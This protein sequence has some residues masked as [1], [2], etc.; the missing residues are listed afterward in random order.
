VDQK[1]EQA[2]VWVK[3]GRGQPSISV[4]LQ[5][6]IYKKLVRDNQLKPGRNHD[7][8]W[9]FIHKQTLLWVKEGGVPGVSEKRQ[10]DF[11]ATLHD[12]IRFSS[13]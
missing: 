1:V 6:S 10:A 13:V 2:K 5:L 4:H 3:S 9:L 12:E 11:A 7:D 8:Y